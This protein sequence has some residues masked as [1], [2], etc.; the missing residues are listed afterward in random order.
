MPDEDKREP[1]EDQKAPAPRRSDAT[2]PF[3]R[4]ERAVPDRR[5]W[6]TR[7]DDPREKE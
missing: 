7:R 5:L 2:A 3:Q 4:L 1:T 6:E